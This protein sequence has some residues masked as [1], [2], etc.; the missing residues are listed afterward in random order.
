VLLPIEWD[1]ET[2]MW[3]VGEKIMST[4]VRVDGT[5]FPLGMRP[6]KGGSVKDLTSLTLM[7]WILLRMFRRA[8]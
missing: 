1:D 5:R 8:S 3:S 4:D 6:K 7:L 2:A